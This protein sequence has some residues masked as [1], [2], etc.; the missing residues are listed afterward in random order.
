MACAHCTDAGRVFDDR[1][2]RWEARRFRWFGP[3]R[4][5][6]HLLRA[7]EARIGDSG[8]LL[9]VGGGVGT[10]PRILADR[11][12]SGT[13]V[14]ASSAYLAV[15]RSDAERHGFDGRMTWIEGDFLDVRDQVAEHDAVTL[16][17]VICCYPD[18]ES[19]VR[20]TAERA[21]RVYVL[22]FP[23]EGLLNRIA[24]PLTN[25]LLR[26]RGSAFRTFMHST[27]RVDEAAVSRGL[28]LVEVRRTLLWQVRVYEREEMQGT[29]DG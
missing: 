22:V 10:I 9:D 1:T 20:E 23:R 7:V 26:I 11:M 21:R 14:D 25:L 15:A 18:M 3:S 28:A 4:P 29:H 2:A 24:F 8:T 6:K 16:D 5:T 13:A 27:S 19:L 17:R 12:A